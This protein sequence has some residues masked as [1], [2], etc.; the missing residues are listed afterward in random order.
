VQI[1]LEQKSLWKTTHHIQIV[2]MLG[3]NSI[4]F[5]YKMHL[6]VDMA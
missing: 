3:G 2:L 1:L 5:S 4:V 6:M